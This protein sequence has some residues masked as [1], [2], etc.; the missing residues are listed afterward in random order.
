[1]K[2]LFFSLT[3]ASMQT[4]ALVLVLVASTSLS[5][6]AFQASHK[7]VMVTACINKS[8]GALR[9]AKSCSPIES[10]FHWNIKGAKGA[11]G[12]TGATGAT[13]AKGAI[14]LTGDIGLTGATGASGADGHDGLRGIQILYGTTDPAQSV[15]LSGD[16]YV[17]TQTNV[18][19]GPKV[20]TW[21]VG[22]SI[23]GPVG[24]TG[25]AG[26]AGL[27]GA[28]GTPGALGAVGGV[29]PTGPGGVAGPSGP[30]G[31]AGASAIA[32]TQLSI[33]GLSGTSLCQIGSIGPGGGI[34]FFVDY[35]NLYPGFNYLEVAP[36]NCER[37]RQ[38]SSDA[39]SS[40]ASVSSWD[41]RAVGSGLANTNAI[42]AAGDVSCNGKSDWF[43]PSIGESL[44]MIA[45]LEGLDL[46]HTDFNY[47]TS[48]QFD[49]TNAA[50]M[51]LNLATIGSSGKSVSIYM[52]PVR[53]F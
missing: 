45:N 32:I 33:C 51:N 29:G 36:G 8:T 27:A 3:R 39:T 41:S 16:F 20:E 31:S 12:L 6:I 14:G 43:L 26:P 49:A 22:V 21:S 19:F 52:R 17:N 42:I 15:G 13:G 50:T 4:K 40:L 35:Q 5:T 18:W 1:M 23:V 53:E 37:Q 9:I 30:A 38:W 28:T 7:A 2:S 25:P 46:F 11:I 48:N 10:E 24:A 44:L 47:W 34:I